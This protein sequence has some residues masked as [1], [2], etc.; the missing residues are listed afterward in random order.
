SGRLSRGRIECPSGDGMQPTAL[1]RDVAPRFQAYLKSQ[2][3]ARAALTTPVTNRRLTV[4][5]CPMLKPALATAPEP[6]GLG[7]I[8][9]PKSN[10]DRYNFSG[11]LHGIL[12]GKCSYEECRIPGTLLVFFWWGCAWLRS[13]TTS[14]R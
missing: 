12:S 3:R 11:A 10:R 4:E 14:R 9:R 6:C 8:C 5:S 1:V 13:R 7:R 2:R